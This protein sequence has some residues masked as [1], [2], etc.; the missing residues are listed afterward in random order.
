MLEVGGEEGEWLNVI[1]ERTLYRMMQR[2]LTWSWDMH[3]STKRNRMSSIS[4]RKMDKQHFG[5]KMGDS[6]GTNT[7]IYIY[8]KLDA[9]I[10]N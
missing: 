5:D 8:N 10:R 9:E 6:Y 4:V 1:S 2:S 3:S 7:E